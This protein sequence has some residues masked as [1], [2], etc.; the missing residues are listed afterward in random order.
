[1]AFGPGF[2]AEDPLQWPYG[3]VSCAVGL[4]GLERLVEL[5]DFKPEST[6]LEKQVFAVREPHFRCWFPARRY[7]AFAGPK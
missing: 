5:A 6:E 3:R 4:V 7:L 2:T 1:M